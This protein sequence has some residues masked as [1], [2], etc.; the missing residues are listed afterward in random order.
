MTVLI[1]RQEVIHKNKSD[2]EM[3]DDEQEKK[4]RRKPDKDE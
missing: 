2:I 4:C 3:H 1:E